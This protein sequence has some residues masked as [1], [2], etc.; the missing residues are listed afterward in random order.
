MPT[1]RNGWANK[2]MIGVGVAGAL[3][4]IGA[5]PTTSIA[6]ADAT[7]RVKVLE[8][9]RWTEGQALRS[10]HELWQEIANIRVDI[11]EIPSVV[12]LTTQTHDI[13]ARIKDIERRLDSIER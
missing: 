11:A 3:A 8:D 6:N 1:E 13:Q 5:T 10:H 7:A 12:N 9:T 2:V 4:I